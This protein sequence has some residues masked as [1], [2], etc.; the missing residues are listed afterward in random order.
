MS[1]SLFAPGAK[2]ISGSILLAVLIL[3]GNGLS[4]RAQE[5]KATVQEPEYL[6]QFAL[7]GSNGTLVPLD[8]QKMTFVSQAH[9]HFFSVSASG[10]KV[11]PG[12]SSPVR[13]SPDAHF[14]VK[15]SSTY[16]SVD[17]NT[18]VHLVPFAIQKGQ[19][20]IVETT[21]KA[22]VFQGA[23]GQSAPDTSIPLNF[24]KYGTS[25]LEIIPAQPLPPGEYALMATGGLA[26]FCFGVDAK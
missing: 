12:K 8:Q 11:V 5:Q 16:D 19:R 17:P 10:E 13:V 7:L 3:A 21:A 24:K 4:L 20:V 26:V 6:G 23:K 2:R 14:V 25:S 22:G 9:N 15:S 1:Y 18:L